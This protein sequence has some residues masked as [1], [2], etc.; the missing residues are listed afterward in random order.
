[1]YLRTYAMKITKQ[2]LVINDK[3]LRIIKKPIIE[4]LLIGLVVSF[5][6]FDI[7]SI[8]YL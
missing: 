2:L 4:Y 3:R 5:F 7:D 1:M 8:L 6:I